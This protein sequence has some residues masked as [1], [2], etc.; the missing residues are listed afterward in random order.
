MEKIL[1]VPDSFKG[2]L[3]S[4]QVCQVMA[5]QLRRFFPQAQVKSIPVADGGEGSVEAFL[6]AAG[7]ERRTR[8]VTGP[9]GEPVEAFYG[10]LGD[11]RTAVIEMAACAG[12]PLAEG[13]LNPERATTYGVGE[14]LLAAKE[15]GCTKAILG[16]GGSCTNDGGAGA[17]AALGAK[18]TRADGAA[19][20][21]TGGTLGEIAALDVSPVAQALQGMELTA[22][23]DI[24]NPLYGEAGAAAVFAPQKG[25]DAAMVARLDAGL[26]HLGQ[27]AARCLGRD[28]SHLPGAGAA[29]GLGFGMAA[30][31]GAQLRM[32]IDAVLDAVGFDSLLPGTDVV[33]T[34]EGKI[35]SQ[36]ARGKVV[37]G[38]AA[39]CR[40]AGVPV[41]AVVGQIDQ[42]FEEMYQQG[43]TAVFSI[44]RAAQPF[45]E[46]RFHAG[47]NLALTMENIARLLAAG[48]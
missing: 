3:S 45:A 6:A 25:A 1:L 39:R 24:D 33:F 36:S 11:G 42:G 37:S 21:P 43:L 4:R 41:V 32:G 27:V 12:L 17:A 31:C 9:F 29:G 47:E 8:T 2:T 18:F 48:R 23:C 35:D 20:L 38:V 40:K 30:F 13:R 19:F 10:V 7:G 28:F 14:L 44:N 46:S 5:G 26:R 16:L 22:M 34:G 15:A